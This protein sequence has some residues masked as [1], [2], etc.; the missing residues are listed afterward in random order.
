[1]PDEDDKVAV[2]CPAQPFGWLVFSD[3]YTSRDHFWAVIG[4]IGCGAVLGVLA[5]D[6]LVIWFAATL[7]P[8]GAVGHVGVVIKHLIPN[9]FGCFVMGAVV[10]VRPRLQP[11]HPTV[12]AAL[13][14][15][16]CGCCTTYSS[17]NTAVAVLF[18]KSASIGEGL[19]CALMALFLG[20]ATAWVCLMLGL[21]SAPQASSPI[22]ERVK[23]AQAKLNKLAATPTQA[24]VEAAAKDLTSIAQELHLVAS[25]LTKQLPELPGKLIRQKIVFY[26]TVL[27]L[28]LA[29]VVTVVVLDIDSLSTLLVA[30]TVAPLGA[31]LRYGLGMRNA[32]H[33]LPVYTLLVNMIAAA[34]SALLAYVL[35]ESC[36]SHAITDPR[37]R[38]VLKGVS[39]GFCGSL[40]TVSSFADEVRR[41]GEMDRKRPFV[42]VATTLLGGQAL[43]LL[44]LAPSF[45]ST[46]GCEAWIGW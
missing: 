4:G 37:W 18:L 34:T 3:Y 16:F 35:D 22:A 8:A 42:Y 46:N 28:A 27:F 2:T 11:P 9:M 29:I 17:Y 15:G 23:T 12:Y 36:G 31:W 33:K 19:L 39:A 44:I 38:A 26:W 30:G 24:D 1:M 7:A 10:A 25:G 6:R 45:A 20:A 43:A 21:S 13:T 41:L 14:T 32:N 40:S 5:R